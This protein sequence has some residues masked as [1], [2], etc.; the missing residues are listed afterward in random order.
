MPAKGF[1][2]HLYLKQQTE[3]ILKRVKEFNNKLYLEF[4]GKLGHDQHAKR[5]LPGYDP[6][7]KLEL[8]KNLK[9][10]LEFILCIYAEDIAQGKVLG[11]LAIT[12]DIATLKLIDDLKKLGLDKV[13]VVITRFKNQPAVVKFK[14]K[15]EKR[16]IK[17]YTHLE[18][19]GYPT[20]VDF[21]VS[22]EG[23]G[24]NC[25]IKTERPIVV[26]NG[27]GPNSGKMATC[28]S[29][30][31][32]DHRKGLNSG[33]AKFETFPIWN[34]P[35]EHMVNVAYEAATADI[36]DY[37]VV[38]P[39]H[40]K[41][42][43][44]VVIN[45]NRDVEAFPILKRILER[46]LGSRENLPYHS[47]T[48]M[49]VNRAGFAIMDDEIVTQ[50]CR[51]ELIRRYFRYLCEFTQGTVKVEVVERIKRLLEENN[52]N[53]EDRKV[54]SPAREIGHKAFEEGQTYQGI[55][56]GAAIELQDG[57]IICAV[58]N[59]ALH[60]AAVLII[61]VLKHLIKL[62]PKIALIPN[63]LLKNVILYKQKVLNDST[64][65]LDLNELLMCLVVFSNTNPTIK[66]ALE[67]LK[68]IKDCPV[69]MTHM[70]TS[71]DDRALRKIGI[72]LTCDPHFSS[73]NLFEI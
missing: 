12:Y 28:L 73:S 61:K 15:L 69:H 23:L 68:E 33:Y 34:L 27:P 72:D 3:E 70:P 2:N 1:D 4:V 46:I 63:E 64:T 21:I 42:Y 8:L 18:I 71:G 25:Y 11:S 29:Q 6:N 57:T 52:I 56:C 67:K 35:L 17:I 37:N 26:V 39:H 58:N 41:K 14:N 19:K 51:Q 54:V 20:D 65:S 53:I 48:D 16:D 32:H 36:G 13:S 62:D 47:P 31:Y 10:K 38:D 55:A 49:G 45:Y 59:Q 60:A 40:L 30:L 22:D 5:V 66:T 44:K 9:D 43:N 50:A 24:K 7:V